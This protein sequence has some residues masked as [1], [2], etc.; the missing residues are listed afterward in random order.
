[1]PY[2]AWAQVRD[3][4]Q[5]RGRL[6]EALLDVLGQLGQLRVDPLL[7]ALDLKIDALVDLGLE[8]RDL[9]LLGRDARFL[10]MLRRGELGELATGRFSRDKF[11]DLA[12]VRVGRHAAWGG[13]RA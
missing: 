13:H 1:M 6:V 11:R 12:E 10:Q 4:L 3:T 8:G 2:P 5:C 9:L 7:Y